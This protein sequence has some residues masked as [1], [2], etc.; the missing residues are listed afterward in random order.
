MRLAICSISS[1]YVHSSLAPWYLEAAVRE[2]C[3][4]PVEPV[5]VEATVNQ[6]DK[7]ILEKLYRLDPRMIGF[8]CTIWNMETVRRIVACVAQLLPQ[9]VLVLGGPEA[10]FHPQ[11]LEEL[12]M[13]H[14][15]VEGE[16]E[17]SLPLLWDKLARG[18]DPA[19]VPGLWRREN[20]ALVGTPTQPLA[21]EPPDPYSP[22]YFAALQGRIAYVETSRGC[23]FS[24]AFCLSGRGDNS[25]FFSLERAKRD[26]L[27]LAGSGAKTI[28]LVDRTFNCSPRRADQI[29]AF[30]LERREAGDIP[31]GVCFHFEV[32]ADLFDQESLALL[33]KAPAGL[34]QLEAGLQ[35]FH[36]PTL[37]AVHRKTDLSKLEQNLRALLAP[38][39]IHVH[40][41]LIA[42]LPLEDLACFGRSFD[43]AYGLRPHMLQLGFLKLLYG[44]G[45]RE[46]AGEHGFCF[47]P[48]PPYQV[49]STR[50]L[51]YSDLLVL[52]ETEDALERL[53]NS[54]RFPRTLDYVL[55]AGELGPFQFFQAMGRWAHRQL[56]ERGASV[57]Q[58]T[59][60][61]W[62]FAASLPG[63]EGEKLRDALVVDRL[64]WDN[65]GRLPPCLF[66]R[67]EDLAGR[68]RAARGQSPQWEQAAR[69][70]RLHG[71]VLST[72]QLAVADASAPSPVTGQF[73]VVIVK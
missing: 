2:R 67:E 59:G 1:Q 3:Q 43:R 30:L 73:P 9:A 24:C 10:G 40:I 53:Y 36:G 65:T 71:A 35:S 15:L 17:E 66:R 20:G 11:L 31:A 50:W 38:G 37:E 7:V 61:L 60:L 28:K 34:F 64:S 45:L 63:V 8:S 5:V 23:P 51:S 58:Y 14:Y 72:G 54:G 12:P 26:L 47:S 39:N 25:R 49:L 19:A 52:E 16:G 6:P 13:V 32:A 44:S 69:Q 21:Q 56:G 27:R 62:D 4:T 29:V 68:L 42:G 41:D 70:G 57:D 55:G 46:E 33:A 22:A 18:E 48:A